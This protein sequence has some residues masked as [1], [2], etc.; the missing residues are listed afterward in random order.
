MK[1]NHWCA[2]GMLAVA[3]G[4]GFLF[5][6]NG[7]PLYWILCAL[8]FFLSG[9]II[10][11]SLLPVSGLQA[12]LFAPLSVLLPLFSMGAGLY[13]FYK[14]DTLAVLILLAVP[15]MSAIAGH[16]FFHA[17]HNNE[18][19]EERP[20]LLRS[21][22]ILAII[23]FC[24]IAFFWY[25]LFHSRTEVALLGPWQA[26]NRPIL[27]SYLLAGLALLGLILSHAPWRITIF[28]L[29][30]FFFSSFSI[31]L[32]LFPLG[33]GFDPHLHQATE[34][35]I[36]EKGFIL[37]KQLY[38]LGQ[39]ALVAFLSKIL[40]GSVIL[41]DRLLVPLLSSVSIPASAF[42]CARAFRLSPR[43]SFLFVFF[44]LLAPFGFATLTVPWNSASL[45]VLV[46][47]YVSIAYIRL[48]YKGM[49]IF[50]LLLSLGALSIHPLAG[51]PL[52]GVFLFLLIQKWHQKKGKNI[53]TTA[54]IIFFSASIP[55]AFWINSGISSQLDMILTYPTLQGFTRF[56][57]LFSLHAESR[58]SAL[59]DGIHSVY[60]NSGALLLFLAIIGIACTVRKTS[61]TWKQVRVSLLGACICVANAILIGNFFSFPS[62]ISYE[63]YAYADRMFSLATLFLIPFALYA[64]VLFFEKILKHSSSIFK[65]L[66]CILFVS[67][68]A[69]S[70][71]LSY[72]SND[73]YRSFHG[74]NVSRAN[75]EAVR[76]IHRHAGTDPYVVLSNQVVAAA[77]IK[78]YGFQTY[79]TLTKNNT[80]RQYF[81]YPIP[82]SSP[83]YQFF[84]DMEQYPNQKTMSSAMQLFNVKRAYF[85][86][87]RYEDRY[88]TLAEQAEQF[89]DFSYTSPHGADKVFGYV[90]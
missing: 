75:I 3:L 11:R 8:Y 29:C 26:M 36:L 27:I 16:T 87:T 64:L 24:F 7:H 32:T 62:L 41:I 59:L 15:Y 84:L 20:V 30:V 13:F 2:L 47:S 82:T 68:L 21:H 9:Q 33:F 37:P 57:N 54:L 61:L 56:L 81:Y 39:Y 88:A 46:F 50:L 25:I 74:Y 78:E 45:L 66:L 38:Y 23:F 80:A 79:F 5:G 40:G 89:A 42:L 77:A 28:S 69:G 18:P 1:K 73:V 83:L 6:W 53:L 63:Q 60:Q 85:V 31:L 86:I 43:S 67:M 17:G 70:L 10:A 35:D 76:A 34:R 4:A 19:H 52:T 22:I 12:F 90:Q 72:P 58:F 55:L 51:L 14:I 65:F 71:Y 49:L 48:K 44:T